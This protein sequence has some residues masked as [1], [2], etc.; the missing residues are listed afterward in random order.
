[1]PVMIVHE[2]DITFA[3]VLDKLREEIPGSTIVHWTKHD[4]KGLDAILKTKPVL[5]GSYLVVFSGQP[6]QDVLKLVKQF[7][8]H[9][10]LFKANTTISLD[11]IKSV[12]SEH[13]VQFSV[14]DNYNKSKE[15]VLEYVMRTLGVGEKVAKSI[16]HRS[17]EYI[18]K[19]VENVNFLSLLP[20]VRYSDVQKYVP[21]VKHASYDDLF[22]H[23]ASVKSLPSQAI[24]ELLRYYERGHKH[25]AK[26]LLKKAQIWLTV[27]S[28][29][30]SLTLTYSNYEQYYA[31]HKKTLGMS[32]K[33][34]QR[35]MKAYGEVSINFL[36][37]LCVRLDDLC[38]NFSETLFLNTLSIG[39][40]K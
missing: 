5:A 29:M 21:R 30:E 22:L 9:T 26:F 6:K 35:V 4:A 1:M 3:P 39:G 16:Y 10:Y 25:I 24:F 36:Y 19:V 32:L 28:D 37:F 33:Q 7:D 34:F 12:L 2:H 40:N 31:Q 13:E 27:F 11:E 8:R 18:P 20:Q 23:V 17:G 15:D 38:N 14:I